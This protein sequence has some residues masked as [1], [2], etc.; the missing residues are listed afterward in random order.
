MS[1]RAVLAGAWARRPGMPAARRDAWCHRDAGR[2]LRAPAPLDSLHTGVRW[3][4]PR[5]LLPLV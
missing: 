5:A 3:W 2:P 1:N 4:M